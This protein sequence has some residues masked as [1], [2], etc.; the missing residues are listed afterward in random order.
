MANL[1]PFVAQMQAMLVNL[2]RWLGDAAEYATTKKFDP[3]VFVSARLAP[4][5]YPLSRQV[6]SAADSAK[7]TAARLA[8]KTPPA[9]PD[10]EKTLEELRA[11][12]RTVT[13]YLD[14]FSEKDFEGA[15]TRKVALPFIPGGTKGAL[16]L[17]YLVKFAQPNF[18]FHVDHAYAILRHNG[19]PLG[20]MAYIGGMPPL[21]DM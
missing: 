16:G 8:G 4:D 17:D 3:N 7:F 21:L 13:T 18:F 11:R 15:E 12:V 5:Q 1:Y 14:T 20:K 2:D 19:V 10:E 9:H 6:Q